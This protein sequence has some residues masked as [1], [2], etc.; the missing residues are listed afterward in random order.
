MLGRKLI[1]ALS[2]TINKNEHKLYYETV[3]KYL[4]NLPIDFD[5]WISKEDKQ[6]AIDTNVLWEIHWHPSTPVGSY[7]LYG[8]S[9]VEMIQ[10][11]DSS[12]EYSEV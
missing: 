1:A 2:F 9:L 10:H 12:D 6:K 7:S 8:T 3:E 5:V 11:I 4:S